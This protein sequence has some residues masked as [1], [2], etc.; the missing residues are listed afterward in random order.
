MAHSGKA[1][2]GQEA[3]AIHGHKFYYVTWTWLLALT[4]VEVF[5]AYE[6]VSLHVMIILLMGLSLVKAG[7]IMANFMH[8]RFEKRNLVLTLVPVLVVAIGLLAVFFPDSFRLLELRV[9]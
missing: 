5:L 3:V 6:Q 1:D 8:L 9:Q 7:L 4:A 2:T